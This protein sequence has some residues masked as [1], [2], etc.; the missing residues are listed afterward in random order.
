MKVKKIIRTIIIF[1]VTMILICV[2]ISTLISLTT[3]NFEDVINRTLNYL[4]YIIGYGS[5]MHDSL[6]IQ[7]VFGVFGIVT[8][9]ILSAYI[10]VNLFW[11][12]DDV[13]ISKNIAIWKSVNGKYYASVLIGNKGKNICKLELSFVAY[14]EKKNSIG[15]MGKTFTYPLLIQNGVWKIDMPV[16]NG[17]LFD[18][19]RIIRKGR[20]DCKIYSTFEYVDSETGQGSIK[21]QEYESDSIF[22][23]VNK[24]GFYEDSECGKKI[25]WR[26][27]KLLDKDS[28]E[29]NFFSNWICSN[30]I[31]F[32]LRKVKPINKDQIKLTIDCEKEL[33]GCV[34]NAEIDFSTTSN[35]PDF[36]MALLDFNKPFQDWTSYYLKG[37]CFQ[38][39]I[40]GDDGI[41]EL[42]LEIKGKS[43]EKLIDEKISVTEAITKY[44]FK[45]NQNIDITSESFSE[46]KEICFTV[47]NKPN[48]MIKGCFKIYSCEILIDEEINVP[49][50]SYNENGNVT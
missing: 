27:F 40:S 12:V 37:S 48:D 25:K 29:D 32:D 39:E 5:L 36:V 42:Q 26:Q 18:V 3:G 38:F 44:S 45:L 23:S 33:K 34:L 31:T 20:K 10:T 30:L 11:R 13:F 17:F 16:D 4:L 49:F 47:F 15:E 46:V 1:I 22:I 24:N 28:E 19:L 14:D 2:L 35:P 41:S 43:G 8:L 7:D 21:V 50:V 9:S 6:I